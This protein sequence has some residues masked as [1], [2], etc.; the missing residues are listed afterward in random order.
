VELESTRQAQV[1]ELSDELHT[2][3]DQLATALGEI[4]RLQTALAKKMDELDT[5]NADIKALHASL[6]TRSGELGEARAEV[7]M[8]KDVI[9][10][11]TDELARS[12]AAIERLNATVRD[13]V[14]DVERGGAGT[15]RAPP[16]MIHCD[17]RPRT[18]PHPYCNPPTH[19]P[20]AELAKAMGVVADKEAE[21]GGLNARI[22]ELDAALGAKEKARAE[23]AAR[24]VAQAAQ[25]A[26][27]TGDKDIIVSKL[28]EDLAMVMTEL[29]RVQNQLHKAQD[30]VA[31]LDP[32]ARVILDLREKQ[33]RWDAEH[34]A[35]STGAVSVGASPFGKMGAL[36]KLG[37]RPSLTM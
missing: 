31:Y 12:H 30:T 20:P 35:I 34:D 8:L 13:R 32:I 4:E 15:W 25:L 1:A 37:P 27:L 36:R 28:T 6:E 24:S 9:A 17:L 14:A 26:S 29:Q 19:P 5:A 22:A 18:P 2:T 11:K 16:T 3:Q 7:R 33:A 23:L 10:G 21:I